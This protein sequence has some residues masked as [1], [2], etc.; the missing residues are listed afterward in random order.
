MQSQAKK[1]LEETERDNM[2]HSAACNFIKI[3][4]TVYHLYRKPSGQSYFSMVSPEEWGASL[5]SQYCGSFRLEMDSSWT[6]VEKIEE[7]QE[8]FEWVQKI[9][10]SSAIRQENNMMAIEQLSFQEKMDL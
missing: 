9:L 1:I 2:L 3:P 6:P 8:T 10:N 4:G 5:N 7:K